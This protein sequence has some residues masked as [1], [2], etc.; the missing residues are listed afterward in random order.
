M[1]TPVLGRRCGVSIGSLVR[2]PEAGSFVGLIV[3]YAFFAIKGEAVFI[4]APGW[5]SWL[6]IAAEVGIVALPVGLLMISGELDISIGAMIP[7]GS[8]TVAIVSGHYGLPITL[9]IACA[10]GRG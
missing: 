3:V 4:G 7:A 2:R 1:P 8:M 9:G 6:N 5:S 10:L